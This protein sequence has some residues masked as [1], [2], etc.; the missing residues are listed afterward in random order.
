MRYKI[1]HF[2]IEQ[3][4]WMSAFEKK[5]IELAKNKEELD[6]FVK[7]VLDDATIC[8]AFYEDVA[9]GKITHFKA[10]YKAS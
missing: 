9:N 5:G 1:V 8:R 6:I 4:N 2:T 7:C 3:V 10:N